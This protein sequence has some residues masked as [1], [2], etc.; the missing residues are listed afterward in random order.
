MSGMYPSL[1][2]EMSSDSFSYDPTRNNNQGTFN[3]PGTENDES[4]DVEVILQIPQEN[5][6]I[7]IVHSNGS[8]EDI[9]E[10]DFKNT[11]E[12]A[13]QIGNYDSR[14]KVQLSISKILP[15]APFTPVGVTMEPVS[16]QNTR[17]ST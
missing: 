2:R 14:S 11:L 15:T 5:L 6:K 13:F 3:L 9:K 17:L 8:I 10:T 1:D 4:D 7:S 16:N 12:A